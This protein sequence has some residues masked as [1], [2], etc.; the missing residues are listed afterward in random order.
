MD[1]RLQRG[2][3][4]L[5]LIST[6]S[7]QFSWAGCF[8]PDG[9]NRNSLRGTAEGDYL[10]CDATA[11][12][13]MCCALG[14]AKD[15]DSC[16][17]GGLCK[18]IDDEIFW[19]ESCTDKTW[20]SPEC[21]KLFVGGGNSSRDVQVSPCD[22]GS[23][24]FGAGYDGRECCQQGRGLFIAN[25]RATRINPNATTP[26][27]GVN[28]SMPHASTNGPA[29][30]SISIAAKAGIGIGVGLAVVAIISVAVILA[31]RK[32]RKDIEERRRE[33]E[34][35]MSFQQDSQQNIA[36]SCIGEEEKGHPICEKILD[37]PIGSPYDTRDEV[38][39]E[40]EGVTKRLSQPSAVAPPSNMIRP[41]TTHPFFIFLGLVIKVSQR[42]LLKEAKSRPLGGQVGD[43]LKG[44]APDDLILSPGS[45]A[46]KCRRVLQKTYS[47]FHDSDSEDIDPPL[48]ALLA[49]VEA[50]EEPKRKVAIHSAVVALGL[51][52]AGSTLASSVG[53]GI[54]PEILVKSESIERMD[55]M[56]PTPLLAH[57]TFTTGFE[58]D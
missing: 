16:L 22:N 20:K 36:C 3:A 14:R 6:L 11:K 35:E 38:T 48:T 23:W 24:C 39:T 34:K 8:L 55:K 13:S 27:T 25:G 19:R 42:A 52:Q 47:L 28:A 57:D 15:P 4:S 32:R 53:G 31:L 9:T 33:E 29:S 17:P 18:S 40:L 26:Q 2:L 37:S 21:I 5:F 30:Q 43:A 56:T 7:V 58:Y 41:D 46:E 54:G 10:P 49:D 1:F 45:A 44:N 50:E 12:V 51:V